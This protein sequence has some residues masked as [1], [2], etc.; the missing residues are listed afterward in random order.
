VLPAFP[1]L[2]ERSR[3]GRPEHSAQGTIPSPKVG[4]QAAS[5]PGEAT[6]I[7]GQPPG[8]GP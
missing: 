1:I 8:A 5:V 7:L 2:P 4:G 6:A 3:D